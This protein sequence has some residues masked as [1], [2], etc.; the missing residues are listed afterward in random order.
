MLG[1]LMACASDK[2]SQDP[3]PV[4]PADVTASDQPNQT[5]TPAADPNATPNPSDRPTAIE[6]PAGP[7]GIVHH[8]VCSDRC[9][10]GVGSA[11]GNCP[12]CGLAMAHNKTYH[13]G[14][15]TTTPQPQININTPDG[16]TTQMNTGTPPINTNDAQVVSPL[17][18]DQANAAN[19][20]Q[21]QQTP[22][23]PPQNASGVWHYTCP[24]GCAGGGGSAT[25]CGVCGTTLAHNTAYHN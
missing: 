3:A 24:K 4:Q 9:E 13:T 23:E 1:L 7:D 17:F 5:L 2:S 21:Q 10:G 16:T 11:A 19:L 8:Y 20:I 15:N 14:G 6:V 18:K 12:V 22:P 25:P